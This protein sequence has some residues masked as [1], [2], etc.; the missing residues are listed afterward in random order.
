MNFK[1]KNYVLELTQKE[2]NELEGQFFS[3]FT[4]YKDKIGVDGLKEIE[5][6]SP[7][8]FKLYKLIGCNR[9]SDE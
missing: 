9:N 5:T 8:L 2:V 3:V 4:N 7:L 6:D 1:P